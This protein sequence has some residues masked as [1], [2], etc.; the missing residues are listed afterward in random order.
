MQVVSQQQILECMQ[1]VRT[2]MDPAQFSRYAKQVLWRFEETFKEI[3]RSQG[4]ELLIDVGCYGPLIGPFY[5]LLGYRRVGAVAMYDWGPLDSAVL[6]AWARERGIDLS[7]W[8]GNIELD[9]I[10]WEANEADVLLML[11]IL[12]H[13]SVDPMKALCDANRVL[14][15]GGKLVL[16]T[17]NAASAY[18]LCLLACGQ[19]PQPGQYNSVDSNRHN[20]LYDRWELIALLKSAGFTD[21]RVRSMSPPKSGLRNAAIRW[22]AYTLSLCS[23][24]IRGSTAFYRGDYLLASGTKISDPV[25]RFPKFLYEDRELFRDWYERVTQKEAT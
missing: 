2:A 24:P 6:P 5:E 20:R 10:P 21:I 4:N 14:R 11:E 1:R 18:S 16:S 8:F 12:E 3:P 13:F 17:P 15:P 22:G 23:V 19:N 7:L 25:D 9:E